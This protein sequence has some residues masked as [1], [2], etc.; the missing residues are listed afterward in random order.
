VDDALLVR[1][2]ER[3]SDL[4]CDGEGFLDRDCPALEPLGEVLPRDELHREEVR[5]RAVGKRRVFEAVDV[6]DVRVVEG[7]EQLRLALEAGEAVG[8]LR[9]LGRQQLDRHVAA[10]LRI[11]RTVDL[12]HSAGAEEADD[13]VRT[14]A[15]TP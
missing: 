14:Y 4:A 5:R 1:F 6:S 15:V 13:G 7:G 8:V 9:Q 2:L 12:A 10:E 11:G 3:F